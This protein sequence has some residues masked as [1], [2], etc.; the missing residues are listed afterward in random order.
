MLPNAFAMIREK[1]DLALITIYTNNPS[2][3]SASIPPV[4]LPREMRLIGSELRETISIAEVGEK[5]MQMPI[6]LNFGRVLT[7]SP[8]LEISRQFHRHNPIVAASPAAAF[9]V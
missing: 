2:V 7:A 9:K 1:A 3:H 8:G 4:P 6:S 5:I